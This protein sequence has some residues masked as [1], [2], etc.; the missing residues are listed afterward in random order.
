M[1]FT[2]ELRQLLATLCCLAALGFTLP[3]Y[4]QSGGNGNGKPPEPPKPPADTAKETQKKIDEIAEASGLAQL[5][6][7]SVWPAAAW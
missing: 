6:T 4:A 5:A 7:Q 2:L 1:R 3:A